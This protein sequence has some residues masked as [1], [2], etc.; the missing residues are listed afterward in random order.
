MKITIRKIGE[1][2]GVDTSLLDG[3]RDM[4]MSSINK[5]P[6]KQSPRIGILERVKALEDFLEKGMQFPD[7]EKAIALDKLIQR[8]M[9]APIVTPSK[10][11][12][13]QSREKNSRV[14]KKDTKLSLTGDTKPKETNQTHSKQGSERDPSREK[15]EE[16]LP[17]LIKREKYIVDMSERPQDPGVPNELILKQQMDAKERAMR[18]EKNPIT[19][20]NLDNFSN[21][22]G[23]NTIELSKNY[24]EYL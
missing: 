9:F 4:A 15:T 7:A 2:L 6:G 12:E 11:P 20:Q 17:S 13:K 19:V 18:A 21:L 5:A 16:E 24:V 23:G 14:K 22:K 8:S 10:K 3:Y 1:D